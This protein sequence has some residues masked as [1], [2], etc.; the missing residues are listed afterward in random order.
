M[1][2]KKRPCYLSTNRLFDVACVDVVQDRSTVLSNIL[3]ARQR[4]PSIS[5]PKTSHFLHDKPD[6]PKVEQGYIKNQVTYQ[7]NGVHYL[8]SKMC[9]QTED[10]GF[11][12]R[13]WSQWMVHSE[14][15]GLVFQRWRR[16]LRRALSPG[17]SYVPILAQA[18]WLRLK[19]FHLRRPGEYWSELRQS[20]RALTQAFRTPPLTLHKQSPCVTLC[21]QLSQ[22]DFI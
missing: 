18:L 17:V 11:P 10:K 8:A 2:F 4:C 13:D 22:H 9:D 3:V 16:R 12:D 19:E 6:R 5:P 21:A 1:P 20:D 15:R 7:K 14:K